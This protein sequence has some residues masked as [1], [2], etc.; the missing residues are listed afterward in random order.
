MQIANLDRQ[1][2]Q[3]DA[4]SFDLHKEMCRR[5]AAQPEL[6]DKLAKR[7]ARI[8]KKQGRYSARIYIEAW[9]EAIKKG[10][11]AVIS[12]ALEKSEWGQ[13]MRSCSPFAV[14][15]DQE[16]RLKFLREWQKK[17]QTYEDICKHELFTD[18]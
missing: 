6:L 18:K 12:L 17:Y 2:R 15:V 14:I 8:L 5:L 3:H 11:D 16:W 13:V 7:N 9:Q 1:H 10:V 4:I